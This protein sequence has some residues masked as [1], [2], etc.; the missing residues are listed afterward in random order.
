MGRSI[1]HTLVSQSRPPLACEKAGQ[2]YDL[3][4]IISHSRW[5][6][7]TGSGFTPVRATQAH[8]IDSNLPFGKG[9]ICTGSSKGEGGGGK[10][11]RRGAFGATI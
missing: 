1:A 6:V 7:F 4:I 9:V 2:V 3:T 11:G 10:H 5:N 8:G